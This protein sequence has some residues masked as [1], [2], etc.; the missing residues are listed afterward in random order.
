M[1]IRRYIKHP[2]YKNIRIETKT[3][4][5]LV[6][7]RKGGTDFSKVFGP[8]QTLEAL[9]WLEDIRGEVKKH[10]N[11]EKY[12]FLLELDNKYTPFKV[13]LDR[14]YSE[15]VANLAT[16]TRQCRELIKP[17]FNDLC[18]YNINQITPLVISNHIINQ[19][20]RSYILNKNGRYSYD[21]ELKVLKAIFNWWR[22]EDYKFHNP[23]LKKHFKLGKIRE[24][25]K[26]Q[27]KMSK[28]EI[29]LFFKAI[30]EDNFWY[31]FSLI[32]F[33][34]AARVSEVAGLQ[35]D[36]IDLKNRIIHIRTISVWDRKSKRFMELKDR[37]K[38]E[39]ERVVYINDLLFKKLSDFIKSRK[40][41]F[42][43]EFERQ[44][45]S[46]RQIQNKYEYYLKKSGAV[47]TT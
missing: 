30:E 7:I 37:P 3:G 39:E 40:R 13:V 23:I 45:L 20:Q 27:L 5:L 31:L 19:K 35:L 32:H 22:E 15:H 26:K 21:Q 41:G 17:F 24:K 8:N 11:L 44:P 34:M 6:N 36:N 33:F 42:L 4:K 25:E 2:T 18:D 16:A 28:E 14:Y 43:F 10:L 46:Y 9:S 47:V 38:N 29:L 1:A 12:P